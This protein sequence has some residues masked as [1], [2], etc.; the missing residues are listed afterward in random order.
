[1]AYKRPVFIFSYYMNLTDASIGIKQTLKELHQYL[2]LMFNDIEQ[3][4][5]RFRDTKI[6]KVSFYANNLI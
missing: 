5:K 3:R 2:V 1:M 6:I 4:R